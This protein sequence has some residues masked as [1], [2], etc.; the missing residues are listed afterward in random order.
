MDEK[1]ELARVESRENRIF[2]GTLYHFNIPVRE[3][4]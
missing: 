2:A 1:G 4:L 3:A